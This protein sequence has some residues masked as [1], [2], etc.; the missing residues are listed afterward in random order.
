MDIINNSIQK[1]N[2]YTIF[3]NLFIKKKT[4]CCFIWLKH[5]NF[6]IKYTIGTPVLCTAHYVCKELLVCTKNNKITV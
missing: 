6:C 1:L 4:F 3:F 5:G 2:T